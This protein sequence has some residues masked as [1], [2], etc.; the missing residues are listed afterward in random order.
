MLNQERVCEMTRLAIFDRKE[1][2]S[3][4]P[5]VQYFRSDYV[6]KEILKSLLSGTLAFAMVFIMWV[7]YG[8]EELLNRLNFAE[9]QKLVM[10]FGG[11]YVGFMAVYLFVTVLVYQRRYTLGR[12]KIKK[13]YAHLKSVNKQ[14]RQEEQD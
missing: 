5:M 4:K 11:Y 8:A 3:C 14:Y 12:R 13:Y 9:L 2:E 6:A 7:L 10:E 1:G